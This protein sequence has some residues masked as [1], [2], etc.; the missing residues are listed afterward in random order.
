MQGNGLHAN[1]MTC[2]KEISI[3]I[4]NVKM[5]CKPAEI[6]FYC[7]R[8]KVECEVIR[9]NCIQLKFSVFILPLKYLFLL[10]F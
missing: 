2:I 1:K 7:S 10:P 4:T 5:Y 8:I 6:C 9:F 3:K